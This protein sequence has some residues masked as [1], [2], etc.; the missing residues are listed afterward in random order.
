M[1]LAASNFAAGHRQ[2]TKYVGKGV[3]PF[4]PESLDILKLRVLLCFLNEDPKTCTVTGLA[5]VLGEGKQKVSRM[6]MALERKGLLDRSDPRRPCLT[7]AGRARAAY[8][9][10]RTN[11]VLNHL[12]YEGLDID[13]ALHD[14]YA[15]A[16]MSSD[17]G[18]ALIR[19]SEQRYRAKY[20]LRRQNAFDGAELC[21]RLGDGE[22][23]FPFLIYKE[24]VSG[25]TNLSM[26]NEGFTHPCTLAVSGGVGMVCLRPVDLSARSQMTGREMNG[27]V[28]RLMY[29]DGD[30]F[31]PAY[32]DGSMISFP[33]R[34]LHFLNIGS[35][36]GQI[37]HGSVCLRMQCS[38]GTK[39]MPEST[40]IFTIL[41]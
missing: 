18:M 19:S 11:V 40:A 25:G 39:H 7:E 8:Y 9:E 20:E 16:L 32:D 13:N 41:I 29:L 24:Y 15:W 4:M 5:G 3:K 36:M 27:R 37:L 22:Y 23:R 26:S 28:R 14:A 30:T 33:A 34:T 12:L 21:R 1:E 10:E 17:E 38:V 35:G 2:Q 31:A 6:L